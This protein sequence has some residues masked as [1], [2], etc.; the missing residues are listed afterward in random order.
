M[1]FMDIGG[2]IVLIAVVSQ[3][4][5]FPDCPEFGATLLPR[6]VPLLL[7]LSYLIPRSQEAWLEGGTDTV[8]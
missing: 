4:G 1:Q 5:N 6:H 2:G 7:G 8:L 3:T